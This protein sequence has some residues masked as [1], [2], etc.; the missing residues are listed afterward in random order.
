MSDVLDTNQEKT[1]ESQEVSSAK[2]RG[3]SG[4]GKAPFG[5]SARRRERNGE[6]QITM[7][8]K[9]NTY[10]KLKE[11]AEEDG[12]P[13]VQLMKQFINEGLLNRVKMKKMYG[14]LI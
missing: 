4:D 1:T 14:D 10:K 11:I 8:L 13:A 12:I 7:F 5:Y 3:K 9:N 6:S 2:K